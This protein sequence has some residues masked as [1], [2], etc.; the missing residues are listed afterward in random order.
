M[1]PTVPSNC[2]R[3]K[4]QPSSEVKNHNPPV[5]YIPQVLASDIHL[6]KTEREK[7]TKMCVLGDTYLYKRSTSR[8]SALSSSKECTGKASETRSS[9]DKDEHENDIHFEC[10]DEPEEIEA[11]D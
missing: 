1:N 7:E 8:K 3:S 11:G 5:A 10:T 2:I 9:S 4:Y 6:T